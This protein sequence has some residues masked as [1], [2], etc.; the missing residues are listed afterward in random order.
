VKYLFQPYWGAAITLLIIPSVSIAD[1][2]A[3]HYQD[4]T[5]NVVIFYPNAPAKLPCKVYYT[6]PD[7]NLMPRTLWRAAAEEN[8]CKR[9][10]D[11]FIVKLESWGW[12]CSIDT[13]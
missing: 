6:K 12:K 9:K 2:W 7:E 5:R 1:S 11:E 3:C 4:L 10:A 13:Q 8:Y